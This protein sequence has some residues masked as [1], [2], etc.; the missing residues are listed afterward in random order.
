MPTAVESK[1]TEAGDVI[2]D[3]WDGAKT[4]GALLAGAFVAVVFG[5]NA[6]NIADGLFPHLRG[7]AQLTVQSTAA[8]AGMLFAALLLWGISRLARV[9]VVQR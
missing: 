6:V 3:I 9:P 5:L 7:G 1:P 8:V 4:G 2:S